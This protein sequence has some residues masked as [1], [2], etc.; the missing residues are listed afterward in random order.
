MYQIITEFYVKSLHIILE[1]RSLSNFSGEQVLSFPSSSSSSSLGVR[2]RDKWFNLALRECPAALKNPYLWAHSILEPMVVDVI[3]YRR[4]IG[5]NLSSVRSSDMEESALQTISGKIVERWVVQY[6]SKSSEDRGSTSPTQATMY[7]NCILLFRSLYTTV[8]L[9]PT[10]KILRDLNSDGQVLTFGLAHRVSSFVQPFASKEGAGYLQFGFTPVDISSGRLCISV[11]YRSSI[12]EEDQIKEFAFPPISS[13]TSPFDSM[14]EY[15]TP[16]P[17]FSPSPSS[18]PPIYIPGTHLHP[19]S[20]ITLVNSPALFSKQN[21][22]PSP[23]SS[24]T[25]KIDRRISSI[26]TGATIEKL[27][28]LGKDDSEKYSRIK[29]WSKVSQQI[30]FSRSSSRPYQDD[31]ENEFLCT[32]DVE[33]VE[34]NPSSRNSTALEV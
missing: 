2:L 31:S 8:R 34:S 33:G 6:V 12:S 16:S 9:L 19:E 1:S 3:C 26:Q 14:S 11:L 18:L 32:F 30:P 28:P 7:R 15:F 20:A 24:A 13:E 23:L 4:D 10:Y 17:S 29:L 5:S 27:P 22:S 25:S 21:L